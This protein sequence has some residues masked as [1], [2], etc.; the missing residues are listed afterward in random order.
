MAL[1]TIIEEGDPKL[2]KI[3][4]RV[5]DI[6]ERICTLLDD[7]AQTMYEAEGVGLAAPQVGILRRVVVIDIG[8]GLIEL[9][10]PEILEQSGVQRGPE[11]CLSCPG[12]S[13]Y[14]DRPDRVVVRGQNRQGETVTYEAEGFLA[15]AMCHEIDHLE[16]VLFIDKKLELSEEELAELDAQFAGD[17]D[18]EEA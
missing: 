1:R 5:D 18:E 9:I 17:E 7:M 15:R 16:G 10:N 8:E 13:G 4:R 6:N 3:S 12:V 11:G 14:V 2:R